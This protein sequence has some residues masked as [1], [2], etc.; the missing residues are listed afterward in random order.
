MDSD[1][2]R[3]LIDA[4]EASLRT[5][6]FDLYPSAR[7]LRAWID[8]QIPQIDAAQSR[9]SLEAYFADAPQIDIERTMKIL[10]FLS[11]SPRI[12]ED[13][14]MSQIRRVAKDNPKPSGRPTKLT[15]ELAAQIAQTVR[16]LQF[17]GVT[18]G[19]A[20][21][22]AALKHGVSKRT[23]NTA[24]RKRGEINSQSFHTM[25]DLWRFIGTLKG[26]GFTPSGS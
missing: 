12:A 25:D 16:D 17:T 23:A 13:T 21:T 5:V 26:S 9:Q 2:V 4:V 11:A 10:A 6:G 24:W 3:Q 19:T 18:L 14:L 20:Q 7:R 22:Q 8:T 1:T 15:P